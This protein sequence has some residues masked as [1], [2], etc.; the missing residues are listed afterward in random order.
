[1]G[2][3]SATPAMR[4]LTLMATAGDEPSWNSRHESRGHRAIPLPTIERV[5]AAPMIT[6]LIEDLGVDLGTLLARAE[7]PVRGSP[8]RSYEVFHVEQAPGSPFIPAQA[9]FVIPHRISSVVGFGGLL[10][11]GELFA[12]VLFSRTPISPRSAA[13]F[14]SIALDIRSSLFGFDDASTWME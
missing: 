12:V 10:R 13:R 3:L 2:E 9:G 4:C 6:R 14:R 1:M 11:T 7:A 8:A 5:R